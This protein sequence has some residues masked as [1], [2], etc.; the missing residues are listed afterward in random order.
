M[1]VSGT[2]GMVIIFNLGKS[3]EDWQ[4][5]VLNTYNYR[6]TTNFKHVLSIALII[7]NPLLIENS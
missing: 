4:N 5:H 7:S 6:K 2:E 1:N 3:Q